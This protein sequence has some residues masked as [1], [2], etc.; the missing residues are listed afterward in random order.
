MNKYMPKIGQ[1]GRNGEIPKNIQFSK[2]ESGRT[3]SSK[4]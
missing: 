4:K 2:T 1:S 3:E